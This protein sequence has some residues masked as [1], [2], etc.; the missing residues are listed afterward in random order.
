MKQGRD[1][2]EEADQDADS[3]EQISLSGLSKSRHYTSDHETEVDVFEDIN[4]DATRSSILD[5][6]STRLVYDRLFTDREFNC[7]SPSSIHV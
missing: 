5:A 1:T 3:F 7:Y 4:P 2:A 6:I